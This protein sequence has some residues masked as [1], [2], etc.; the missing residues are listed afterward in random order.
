MADEAVDIND[1]ITLHLKHYPGKNDEAF[2]AHFGSTATSARHSVRSILEEAM[3][4]KPDWNSMS[5][6]EAGDFVESVMHERHPEL[7]PKALEC[8]GNYYT[9]L[10]R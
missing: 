6:N 5:L 8:I 9:Y 1:A 10:M 4:L 2:D 3:Q 7:S